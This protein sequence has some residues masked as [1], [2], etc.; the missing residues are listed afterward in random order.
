M[1]RNIEL[2]GE[3]WDILKVLKDDL[4]YHSRQD[5]IQA[6]IESFV[7]Q[8]PDA[9]FRAMDLTAKRESMDQAKEDFKRIDKKEDLGSIMK[10]TMEELKELW[11]EDLPLVDPT[12]D[13][14]DDLSPELQAQVDGIKAQI[15]K[16]KDEFI[17]KGQVLVHVES[18]ELPEL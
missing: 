4:G 3:H 6:V 17:E 10:P 8:F 11:G 5:L 13:M 18:P 15:T 1:R 9:K 2:P 7:N 12:K 16:A 14:P